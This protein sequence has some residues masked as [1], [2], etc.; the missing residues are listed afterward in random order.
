MAR[1]KPVVASAIGGL[2]ELIEH[3]ETGLLLPPGDADA[4]ARGLRGL[5]AMSDAERAAMGAKARHRALTGF[6]ANRYYTSM[7][8]LYAGLLGRP[9]EQ[10]AA[11][12]A[13]SMDIA[14][15]A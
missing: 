9:L 13:P 11:S 2:P 5:A 14:A 6:A 7:A 15:P 10:L 12:A 3:G 8:T 1:G 4:L